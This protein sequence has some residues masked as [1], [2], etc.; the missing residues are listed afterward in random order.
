MAELSTLILNRTP[1]RTSSQ[2]IVYLV[3][4]R[5]SVSNTERNGVVERLCSFTYIAKP[6]WPPAA[7]LGCLMLLLRLRTAG[8]AT[9]VGIL[10]NT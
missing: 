6:L 2:H 5:V 8:T 7:R 3:S 9:F 4:C 1:T 10:M